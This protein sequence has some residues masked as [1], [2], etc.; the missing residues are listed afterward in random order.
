MSAEVFTIQPLVEWNGFE[1]VGDSVE[2]HTGAGTQFLDRGGAQ[3]TAQEW[4]D[5]VTLNAGPSTA[6]TAKGD[7]TAGRIEAEEVRLQ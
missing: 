5:Y 1:P 2:V 7:Y 6:A 4:Y 3:I